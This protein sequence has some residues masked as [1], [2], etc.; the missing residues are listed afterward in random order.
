MVGLIPRT[1]RFTVLCTPPHQS[2]AYYIR[3]RN[4][5]GLCGGCSF[6]ALHL[7]VLTAALSLCMYLRHHPMFN[8]PAPPFENV[9]HALI[10]LSLLLLSHENY[11]VMPVA[12]GCPH[13]CLGLPFPVVCT[14]PVEPVS[15]L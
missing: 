14:S 10:S 12:I 15:A 8:C 5:F 6:D 13:F 9:R 4:T 7:P 1:F 11:G 3:D 2:P